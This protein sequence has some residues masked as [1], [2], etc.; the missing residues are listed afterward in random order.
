MSKF[1]SNLKNRQNK[2]PIK[3]KATT[4]VSTP[5]WLKMEL[6]LT[7][8]Y[9]FVLLLTFVKTYEFVYD[10]KLHL[11]G[12]NVAYY[13]L[14][15]SIAEGKGYTNIHMEG[16][17][18][19]NHFPPGYSAIVAGIMKVFNS[20]FQTIKRANGIFY[21]LS[22]L[23]LFALFKKIGNNIH[24]AFIVCIL[25]ILNFHLL[26]YSFI[27]MSEIPFLLFSCIVIWLYSKLNSSQN[28][29]KSIH[30]YLFVFTLGFSYYIRTAGIALVGGIMLAMILERNWKYL[31]A[32]ALGFILMVLPWS[33]R[34]SQL[35]G[36]NYVKQLF[37]I[38]PYR[39]EEGILAIG[40]WF[41]R[42]FVNFKRYLTRE[43]PS[44][45][46]GDN[47]TAYKEDIVLNEYL[48]GGLLILLIGFGIWK[49]KRLRTLVIGYLLGTFFILLL[50]PDVWFGTRFMIPVIPFVVFLSIYGV[51]ALITLVLEKVSF[52][53]EKYFSSGGAFCFF[54]PYSNV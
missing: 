5:K 30:F 25:L 24:L 35:G 36:N 23:I 50:W 16:T 43:I 42:F 20:D 51:Y 34:G 40:D 11:G 32:T 26:Q 22:L 52:K 47:F 9:V 13:I 1:K 18:A 53:N 4:T 2:P 28:P 12:D 31:A 6:F 38:N 49:L 37:M 54:G 21:F 27:M 46:T 48:F 29:L 8:L 45:V 41:T 44:S 17:P 19:A 33:I 14:G 7:I 15:K 3:P 10:K 39:P